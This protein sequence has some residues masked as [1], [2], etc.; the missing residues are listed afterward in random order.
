MLS[1]KKKDSGSNLIEEENDE[2]EKEVEKENESKEENET[3]TANGENQADVD[4][5]GITIV[6]PTLGSIN[7]GG[8]A[9][10]KDTN[11][12]IKATKESPK[13]AKPRKKREYKLK[14]FVGILFV[15]IVIA[16]ILIY[17]FYH[18]Q[19]YLI[20]IGRKIRFQEDTRVLHIDRINVNEDNVRDDILLGNL[21]LNIPYHSLPSKCSLEEDKTTELCLKWKYYARLEIKYEVLGGN[22]CYNISW[23]GLN[24]LHEPKDCFNLDSGHW[25]GMGE[26]DPQ[27]WPLEKKHIK[28]SPF[29]SGRNRLGDRFG[30]VLERYLLQSQGAVLV[31]D[32]DVP[33]HV[34]LNQNNDS[35]LCLHGRFQDSPFPEINRTRTDTNFLRYRICVGHNARKVQEFA[36]QSLLP[37]PRSNNNYNILKPMIDNPVWT[38]THRGELKQDKVLDFARK[39]KENDF[40]SSYLEISDHWQAVHGDL[41]FDTSKFPNISMLSG[42]LKTMGFKLALW[43]HPFVNVESKAFVEGVFKNYWVRGPNNQVSGLTLSHDDE[44]AAVLDP[45]NGDATAWF[46][47]KL[48]DLAQTYGIDSFT[49]G[50]KGLLPASPT[51]ENPLS[52]IDY[53]T[54]LYADMVAALNMP[55]QLEAA[56][57]SQHL[58]IV[59]KM[60]GRQTNWGY[61]FGLKSVIPTALALSV[62][63]YSFVIPG[64]IG[65]NADLNTMDKELYIRWM[66]VAAFMPVMEFSV[67]PWEL[68]PET[69]IIAKDM[70][71]KH[72]T[73]VVPRIQSYLFDLNCSQIC[74]PIIQPLWWIAPDDDTAQ[75]IDSEFLVGETLLVAPILEKSKKT[76]DIYFPKGIWRDEIQRN[77]ITGPKW[78]KNYLVELNQIAYFTMVS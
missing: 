8:D 66:E 30:Q 10:N 7:A 57:R 41:I 2:S 46:Q 60:F 39:I 28:L 53:Y 21:G 68:D 64:I 61:N 4:N 19:Q 56:S 9:K 73:V 74:P 54:K 77:S 62:L 15:F 17:H 24:P 76:R 25:Y 59:I 26:L 69:V 38:M 16:V 35:K 47:Q 78:M 65:G 27:M 36:L 18:E 58:P 48:G 45:T 52:D 43:I 33:L 1:T 6:V 12:D 51:F 67:A 71:N 40:H 13:S 11:G 75:T 55:V 63:G 29:L 49:F 50:G 20:E 42:Q 23:E 37:T 14:A 31:V 70:I 72:K 22:K 5:E 34:S 3:P 32:Y 44:V